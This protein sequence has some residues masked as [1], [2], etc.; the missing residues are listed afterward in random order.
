MGGLA[1]TPLLFGGSATL[2]SGGQNQRW[3][4]NGRIGY[5]TA[6][7]CGARNALEWGDK[8]RIKP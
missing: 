8:I 6:T 2:H 5:I 1:T 7:V 4:M 3:P